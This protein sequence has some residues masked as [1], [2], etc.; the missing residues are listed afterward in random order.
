[1]RIRVGFG[2]DV[3]QLAEGEEFWLGGILIPHTHG[4]VGH[5]DADVLIHVICDALLGAADLR[6]IGFHFPDTSADYKGID[7]KILLRDVMKLIRAKGYE[8]GNIDSTICLQR[9]KINPHIPEMK[10]VLAEVMGIE[11]GDVSIKATT[12]ERLGFVGR[13]E[14][15][16]AYCTV[17]IQSV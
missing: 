10:H 8:V 4:A 16:S 13:E 15:V 17:L 5:S 14:G 7:S 1:M 11:P 3:H 6:D 9:P 2:Y 12:T